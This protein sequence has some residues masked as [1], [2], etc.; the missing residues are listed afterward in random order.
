MSDCTHNCY[1]CGLQIYNSDPGLI[2]GRCAQELTGTEFAAALKAAHEG[3]WRRAK[4]IYRKRK[5]KDG[6]P[7]VAL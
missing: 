5:N 4:S 7:A 3:N 2:C 6:F 1:T